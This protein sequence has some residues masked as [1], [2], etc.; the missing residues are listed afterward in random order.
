M[1]QRYAACSLRRVGLALVL[2]TLQPI[3]R[4][5]AM[6]YYKV[7]IEVWCDWNPA[8]SDLEDIAQSMGVG[9]ALCTKRE[10][11][12]VVDRP[13]DI[14]DEEAMSFFGGEQGDADESQG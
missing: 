11:V 4:G 2:G 6:A 14:E 7:R 3:C 8:E 9:E 13:Q 1:P 10:V 12:A 5:C